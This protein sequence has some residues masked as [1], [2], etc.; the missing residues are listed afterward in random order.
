MSKNLFRRFI[1]AAGAALVAAGLVVTVPTAADAAGC[2]DWTPV[3][4]S[5][6]VNQGL[7]TY[8]PLV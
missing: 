3:L 6:T 8:S 4:S 1:P 7:G 5:Y 2:T